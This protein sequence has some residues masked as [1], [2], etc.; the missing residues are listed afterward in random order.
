MQT[1]DP[2]F[3]GGKKA[4][5]QKNGSGQTPRDLLASNP[6]LRARLAPS[7]K[8]ELQKSSRPR[9]ASPLVR[10]GI[11]LAT[12]LVILWAIGTILELDYGIYAK[13]GLAFLLSTCLNGTVM[14]AYDDRFAVW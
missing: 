1:T 12:P 5:V 8:R 10:Q 3:K 14:F 9:V 11:M 7:A 13:L 6:G 2:A 4:L